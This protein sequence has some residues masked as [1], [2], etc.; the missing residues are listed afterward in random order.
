MNYIYDN[1]DIRVI[2]YCD[3]IFQMYSFILHLQVAEY[4]KSWYDKKI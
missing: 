1:Y 4:S 2:I 3:I